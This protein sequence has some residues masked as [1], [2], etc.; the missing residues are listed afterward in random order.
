MLFDLDGTLV[1]TAADLAVATNAAL[2]AANLPSVS[3]RRLRHLIGA[4]ARAL[5]RRGFAEHGVSLTESELDGHVDIFL[6]RYQSAIADHSRPFPGVVDALNR[7]AD[8]GARLAVCTNKREAYA[9]R[10]LDALNL[11][12]HFTGV[13]GGDTAEAA[14]PD[15]RPVRLALKTTGAEVGIFVGDSD[16]DIE[17]AENAGLPA[18]IT[19]L[20]YGPLSQIGRA[21]AVF[22]VFGRL[23]DLVLRAAIRQER[24][25]AACR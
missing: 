20:G 19:V 5:V 24:S 18:L 22:G 15:A 16:T 21:D 25:A 2:A 3:V 4:G 23:P 8:A 13:I 9:R 10:L 7:L 14:K 17:A 12:A 6:Q 11:S 1:D